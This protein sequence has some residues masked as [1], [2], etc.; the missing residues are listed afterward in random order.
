MVALAKPSPG[1]SMPW[2]IPS[3]RPLAVP[4][5]FA[6]LAS[7]L[8]LSPPVGAAAMRFGLEDFHVAL[9]PLQGPLGDAGLPTFAGKVTAATCAGEY[10]LV[11]KENAKVAF[12][13]PGLLQDR[14]VA[15]PSAPGLDAP[16][17][18]PL[19]VV[20]VVVVAI[21][22][23]PTAGSPPQPEYD[24][25]WS[26]S[27]T[28]TGAHLWAVGEGD[29]LRRVSLEQR[30]HKTEEYN[31]I[32]VPCT[33]DGITSTSCT[34]SFEVPAG[35]PFDGGHET[36]INNKPTKGCV[37]FTAALRTLN[38]AQH[39]A[40]ESVPLLSATQYRGDPTIACLPGVE[41]TWTLVGIE[42][43]QVGGA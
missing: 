43:Q 1:D 16:K 38:A 21:L 6:L 33:Y 29:L 17:A 18:V 37:S 36:G 5:L 12:R 40:M 15:M 23:I 39:W 27:C 10:K 41:V 25:V 2:R 24:E 3:P 14:L 26:Y 20:A 28:V 13:E 11:P 32:G 42:P 7:L 9:R 31:E 35:A 34:A 4:V 30:D 19:V 22:L 8:L